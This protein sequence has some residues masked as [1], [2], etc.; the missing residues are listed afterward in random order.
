[1]ITER[2]CG[3]SDPIGIKLEFPSNGDK[4]LLSQRYP[5][6]STAANL[7]ASFGGNMRRVRNESC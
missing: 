3:E 5:I 2:L 6:V 1:M 4:K 7:D